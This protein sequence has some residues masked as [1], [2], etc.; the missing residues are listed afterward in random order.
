MEVR[1]RRRPSESLEGRRPSE[2][3]ESP[4]CDSDGQLLAD[5]SSFVGEELLHGSTIRV[6]RRSESIDFPS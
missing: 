4:S 2:S 5:V 3:L 1:R 6:N